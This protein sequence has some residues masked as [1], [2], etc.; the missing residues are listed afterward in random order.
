MGTGVVGAGAAVGDGNTGGTV[1]DGDGFGSKLL[2]GLGAGG[3]VTV[4]VAAA[5]DGVSV[6]E[7]LGST[8]DVGDGITVG[9]DDGSTVGSLVAVGLIEGVALVE[10][11][12]DEDGLGEGV[13]EGVAEELSLGVGERLRVG[14]G[15]GVGVG[16]AVGAGLGDG[17]GVGSGAGGFPSPTPGCSSVGYPGVRSHASPMPSLS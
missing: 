6:G 1:A 17:D 5:L 13:A 10:V 9:E 14:D 3:P 2:V 15:V 16:D 12:D 4:G 8:V 11:V 7:A